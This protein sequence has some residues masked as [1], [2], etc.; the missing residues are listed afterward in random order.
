MLDIVLVILPVFLLI[1][2]G[3]LCRRRAFPGEGFWAPAEKL[4]YFLLF[5]ALLV[6][7]LAEADFSRLTVLP[8]ALATAAVALVLGPLLTLLPGMSMLVRRRPW[9]VA[10]S[11]R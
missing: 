10:A 6:I 1:F 8:A 5:P 7:A 11:S 3:Q 9:E 2:L 4:T